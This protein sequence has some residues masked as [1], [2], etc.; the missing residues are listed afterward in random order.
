MAIK[1]KEQA[2]YSSYPV[3]FAHRQTRTEK[4]RQTLISP[5]PYKN[6]FIPSALINFRI[7][8]MSHFRGATSSALC[9]LSDAMVMKGR[10]DIEL[11]SRICLGSMGRKGKKRDAAATLSMLPK[12]APVVIKIYFIELVKDLRPSTIP[13]WRRWMV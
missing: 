5:V 13:S 7:S 10:S 4:Y 1:E 3:R 6:L 9:T 2:E 11:V 12:V 8:F